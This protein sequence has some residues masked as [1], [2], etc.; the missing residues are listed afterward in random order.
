MVINGNKS[1]AITFFGCQKCH[2]GQKL[3][4]QSKI[5]W[6]PCDGAEKWLEHILCFEK[7]K[8]GNDCVTRTAAHYGSNFEITIN[9]IYVT[10]AVVVRVKVVIVVIV[11][12]VVVAAV[13]V[14]VVAVV[15]VIVIVIV[16]VVVVVVAMQYHGCNRRMA[17]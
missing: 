17:S 10:K 1:L 2:G 4:S 12:V 16:I 6:Y 5:N 9:C 11:L 7:Y 14:V 3:E 13:A 15:V 8:I